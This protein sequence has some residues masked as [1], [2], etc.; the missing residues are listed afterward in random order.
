MSDAP[1]PLTDRPALLRS[2]RQARQQDMFLHAQAVGDVQDRLAMV[3]RTFKDPVI[4]S[5]HGAYW[6]RA[7]GFGSV[8][9]DDTLALE[10][11]AHDLVIHAMSLHWANDPVGQLIQCRR[12]LRADGL[13]LAVFPG[14]QTLHELRATL[15]QAETRL[16]GGLSPRVLPMGDLR[17][18]GALL[19]RANFALPVADSLDFKAEYDDLRSLHRDLK[20]MGE[21]NALHARARACTA[22]RLFAQAE[23]LH[24][25]AFP[26]QTKA[27]RITYELI[28]LTG[29]APDDSQQKPLRPGSAQKRL[30]EA[31]GTD[32]TSLLD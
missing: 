31:L 28:A 26:G 8:S 17:D 12:A 3:N 29:W 4:V 5:G 16:R 7:L 24:R 21:T 23:T 27:L 22:P 9:D 19:Q 2:R 14:G 6:T 18:Y 15:A 30:S 25:A 32:E 20:D 10:P 13:L 11:G 1:K